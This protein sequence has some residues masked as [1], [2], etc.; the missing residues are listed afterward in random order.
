MDCLQCDY[1]VESPITP[2]RKD[3]FNNILVNNMIL[4]NEH[5]DRQDVLK[6]HR[7][8]FY[9]LKDLKGCVMNLCFLPLRRRDFFGFEYAHLPSPFLKSS[10]EAVWRE[11]EDWLEQTCN[12]RFRSADD[13]NQ[14]IFH[15]YQYVNGLFHPHCWRKDG[16]AV[17][18]NDGENNNNVKELCD[19]I[20]NGSYKMVCANE[21]DVSDFENTKAAIIR[22]FEELLPEKSMFEK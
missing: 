11:S 10:L 16:L 14:Y 15:N 9:S 22:A 3:I 1:A 20:R 6:K 19:I 12:H 5:Y 7:S 21:A 13:V 18:I 2:N 17:Q 4:L 8:K